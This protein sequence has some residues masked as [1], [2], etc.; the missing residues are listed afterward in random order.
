[1]GSIIVGDIID[2]DKHLFSIVVNR[3]LGE[4]GESGQDV[5]AGILSISVPQ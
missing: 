2:D 1:M 5:H 4:S 3:R